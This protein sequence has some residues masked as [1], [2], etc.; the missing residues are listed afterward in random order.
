VE[1]RPHNLR[2][3]ADFV[4]NAAL[5]GFTSGRGQPRGLITYTGSGTDALANLLLGNAPNS[6]SYT[7]EG[8]PAMDT[9]NWESGY[10]RAGRFFG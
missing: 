4:R 5:D 10:F 7:P 6:V 1:F 2:L 9:Y 3:G 8:R